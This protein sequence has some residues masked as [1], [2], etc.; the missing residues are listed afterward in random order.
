MPAQLSDARPV[1]PVARQLAHQPVLRELPVPHHGFLRDLQDFRRLLDAQ[2]TEE[3]QL[4]D[5]RLSFVLRRQRPQRIVDR[6]QV[7]GT[8]ARDREVLVE[9]DPMERAAA[10]LVVPRPREIH[11]HPA[12]QAGSHG[13][14]V[15]AILPLDAPDINQLGCR[16]R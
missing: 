13:E 1:G 6:D 14:E 8:V 11:E 4:D 10:L 15:R 9:R 12:H 2:P 7:L 3:P 5:L 16:P